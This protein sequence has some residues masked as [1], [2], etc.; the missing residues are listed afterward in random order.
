MKKHTA[1]ITLLFCISLSLC[2]CTYEEAK[3]IPK[4][5]S[6]GS[7]FERGSYIV[8]SDV[9]ILYDG[10]MFEVK[11]YSDTIVRIVYEIVGV[12]K[13]GSY[14]MIQMGG[15]YWV[16]QVQYE[17]DLAENC[18]AIA[19]GTNMIRPGETRSSSLDVFD[20][21]NYGVEADIDQD[22]Y[23]DI[24]FVVSPQEDENTI[25]ASSTDL[26][27]EIYKLKSD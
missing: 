10:E 17:K 1:L 12:K 20:F 15:L 9:R 8:I 2:S 24:I 18:W 6:P 26:R 19:G 4:L 7:V 5:L 16:D 14:E 23:Y 3:M 27:S 22:G 25:S 11:N 13:D 21:G